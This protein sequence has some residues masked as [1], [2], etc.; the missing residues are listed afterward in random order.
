LSEAVRTA[1]FRGENFVSVVTY[2]EVMLK[3]MKGNLDVGDPQKWWSNSLTQL[4]ATTLSLRSEHI[5]TLQSLPTI[6]RDPF[7][8]ILLAQ[9]KEENLT[10]LTTDVTVA[11]YATAQLKI[12]R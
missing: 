3:Y 8:R 1:L 7:D 11:S 6:H 2:W 4:E 5:A 9:A 12:I 10:L